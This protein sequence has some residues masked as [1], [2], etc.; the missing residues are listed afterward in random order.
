MIFFIA[1]AISIAVFCIIEG[2]FL[3]LRDRSNPEIKRIKKQLKELSKQNLSQPDVSLLGHMRP[4]SDVPWLNKFLLRFPLAKRMDLF[5]IQADVSYPLGV[6][7]LLSVVLAL[8]GFLLIF[9]VSRSFLF[10]LLGLALGFVPYFVLNI[11]KTR[12]IKKFEEQLPD[13]LDMIA[14]SLRAGHALASGLEM[15]GQEFPEPLGPEFAKTVTQITFGVGLEQALRNMAK[16]IDCPDLK[17]LVVS[18][19]IQRESGGNLGEIMEN[20]G[21]IIRERFK[22]RGKIRTLA[23]E[24][25]LSAIILFVLPFLI[26]LVLFVINPAY[27]KE[28][29]YDPMGRMLIAGAVVMMFFGVF[30]YEEDNQY[31]GIEEWRDGF[32]DSSDC[33]YCGNAYCCERFHVFARKGTA[34]GDCGEGYGIFGDGRGRSRAG[35]IWRCRNNRW[36]DCLLALSVISAIF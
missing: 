27:I 9:M 4:L 22:L 13:A 1:A 11:M 26:A 29:L 28:L 15:V 36:P 25:K 35:R 34:D 12:R 2:V 6:F 17:F 14:R 21:R 24:G 16:R 19:I 30:C 7:L 32:L 33:F 20:I 3:F 5:L 10:S 23:A 18:V 8:V 31:K